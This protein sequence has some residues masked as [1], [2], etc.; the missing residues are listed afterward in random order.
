M[1]DV[2]KK[3][4]IGLVS[5]AVLLLL[6][7]SGYLLLSKGQKYRKLSFSVRYTSD[8]LITA[9]DLKAY[10]TANCKPVVGQ[11]KR[12][13]SLPQLEKRIRRWPYVDTVI[14][15]TDIKGGMHIEAVQADII[16][17]VVNTAGQSY[18]LARSGNVGKVLPY[19][20]GR[21]VRTLVAN[22]NISGIPGSELVRELQDTSV[23]YDLM[24]IASQIDASPFWKAQIGQIYVKSKGN[25]LLVPTVGSH[26]IEL[27]DA[28]QLDRKFEN[29]WNIYTQGFNVTGWQRYAKVSL[30]YGDRVPCEKRTN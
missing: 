24:L 29:L 2:K 4:T 28:G 27:G 16:L 3:K 1:M 14:I 26:V 11:L 5:V 18:Y 13:V 23:V 25:Y 30:Q 17:R 21:P 6:C 15:S 10:V 19:L 22:G 7:L 8:T 9:K 12:N 20:P